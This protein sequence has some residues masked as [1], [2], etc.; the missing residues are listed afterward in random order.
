MKRWQVLIAGAGQMAEGNLFG[1]SIIADAR[2]AGRFLGPHAVALTFGEPGSDTNLWTYA[3]LNTELGHRLVKACAFGT[4]VPGIRLD[5]LREIPIPIPADPA[6]LSRVAGA[7][8]T[9]VH[10]REAFVQRVQVARGIIDNLPEMHEA[11]D[12]CLHARRK[13]ILWSGELR[14]LRAWNY[15]SAGEA[16][17]H[18]GRA[19]GGRVGDAVEKNG[20]FGGERFPRVPCE[21]PYGVPL[22]SQ[23]DVFS[24][25]PLPRRIRRPAGLELDVDDSTLLIASRGQMNQGTL[26]GRIERGAHMERNVIVTGDCMRMLPRAGLSEGLYAYLSTSVGR[27]LLRSTAYGTSI[28][29]MRTDLITALPIPEFRA[30]AECVPEVRLAA[31]ARVAASTAEAEANRTI[32]EE[33][34]PLWLV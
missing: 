8:R 14:T 7:V 15:V 13:T 4:S 19:W 34:L 21:R 12:M 9:C 10:Q 32:E 25:H 5:L 24:I 28:P 31:A 30:L 18:L 6:V 3:F 33:L 11:R 29:A 22:F 16:N 26:F 2:L 17:S 20:I 23:R 1:R 27:A